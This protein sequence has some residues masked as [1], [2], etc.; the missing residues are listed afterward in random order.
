[1]CRYPEEPVHPGPLGILLLAEIL[2][3]YLAEAADYFAAEAAAAATD[4]SLGTDAQPSWPLAP[5]HK[6]SKDAYQ[7]RCWGLEVR[8]RLPWSGVLQAQGRPVGYPIIGHQMRSKCCIL[9]VE[10]GKRGLLVPSIKNPLDA[11]LAVGGASVY[12][13][14]RQDGWMRY[15]CFC[16]S[17]PSSMLLKRL[18]SSLN[19]GFKACIL[20]CAT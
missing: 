8:A 20:Y 9:H 6:E 3:N 12:D 4:G 1:V 17:S 7:M 19:G 16:Q 5:I 15:E 2:M 14:V 18:S 11:L 10:L 13:A